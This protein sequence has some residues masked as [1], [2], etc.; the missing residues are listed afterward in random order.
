ME[1]NA[2]DADTPR[3]SLKA[4]GLLVNPNYPQTV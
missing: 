1:L 2:D 4:I 3:S